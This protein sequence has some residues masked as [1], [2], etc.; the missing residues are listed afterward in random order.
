MKIN[1]CF[2]I[3]SV[4]CFNIIKTINH[5][6]LFKNEMI[7]TK[8]LEIYQKE[9]ICLYCL[10]RL[11]SLLGTDTTNKRRGDA[12]LL[13]LTMENHSEYLS[14]INEERINAIENLKILA[15][16]ARYNSAQ[17]VLKKEGIGFDIENEDVKCYLCKDIYSNLEM[18][19]EKAKKKIEGFEFDTFL[20]GCSPSSS[21]VNREDRFKS[22]LNIIEAESF[23]SHFNREVGK[24]LSE[25]FDKP[26]EFTYPDITFIFSI[27]EEEFEI[28]LLIRSIFIFG[29]YKKLIRGIPQTHWICYNCNG[30]GCN[31]CD[32]TGKRYE[33][34]V[35]ELINPK[36][37]EASNA[38][39]SK[40]HGAGREDID[41][42]MLGDG[43]PFVLELIEPNIRTLNLSR[44]KQSVN[45]INK[46]KIEI[47]D[48][49]YSTKKEVISM[50]EKA[51]NTKKEY[52]AL[53][54]SEIGIT[55]EDFQ[56]KLQKLKDLLEEEKIDQ[57]TPTRVS[58]R[59]ADK[60]RNKRIYNISGKYRNQTEFEFKIETQGGTYIKEL[61]SGDNGRTSPSFSEIIGLPLKCE[62]LDVLNIDY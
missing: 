60:I 20:V 41:V 28:N 48:L 57:R 26:A 14:G 6:S 7:F 15:E 34:S 31:E 27:G 16:C 2:K 30:K 62:S 32:H 29:R 10:G 52:F 54:R 49:R 51:E 35:E 36:F 18:Y 22:M 8:V 38:T 25:E 37:I 61:I 4:F 23:K 17:E 55:I 33:T 9:H 40:F 5:D 42:K 50:K 44:L 43:R 11:F 13:S 59:R 1:F 58:H 24:L 45:E 19:V 56:I 53:V 12:L 3:F 46:D 39:E 47:S 21:I